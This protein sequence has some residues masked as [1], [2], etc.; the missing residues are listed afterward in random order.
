MT[1]RIT[2]HVG[3]TNSG[4][5]YHAL[6]SLKR[7]NSGAYCGP[8]RL[9]ALEVYEKVNA[10]GIPCNLLTGQERREVESAHHVSSTVEMANLFR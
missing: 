4:K 2:Y 9:L 7:G 6:E 1:R 3:P 5:T 8:L 10:A